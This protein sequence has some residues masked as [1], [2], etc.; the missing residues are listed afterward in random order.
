MS[1]TSDPYGLAASGL[2]PEL[3]AQYS[4]LTRQQAIAEAL[5]KQG[6]T[7]LQAPEVKGRFQGR[8][9]PW[10]GLAKLAQA[11]VG[12]KKLG[13]VQEGY[14]GL[15]NQRQQMVADALTKY[16]Q[17]KSGTPGQE[18]AQPAMSDEGDGNTMLPPAVKQGTHGDPR[19]ALVAAT[20]NPLLHGNPVVAA[21]LKKLEP[22]WQVQ[23]QFDS[24]GRKTKMLVNLNNPTETRPFGGVE[25][26]KLE[27]V[28]RANAK[29]G[30]P[31]DVFV[32]PQTQTEAIPAPVKL[33]AVNLGGKTEFRNP[34]QDQG[35]MAHTVSPDT[36]Y[37]RATQFVVAGVDENGKP[38][39]DTGNVVDAVG[40][41]D[42]KLPPP[43]SASKNPAAMARYNG[44]IGDIKSKYPEW[45]AQDYDSSRAALIA[46]SKGPEAKE[47]RNISTAIAHGGVFID[48]VKA[49]NNGDAPLFNKAANAIAV[50]TG[51]PAPTNLEAVKQIYG[52]EM[53]KAIVGGATAAEDRKKAAE[54]I[55]S[56]GSPAQ[57]LGVVQQNN[58]LLQGKLQGLRRQY[59]ASTKRKDFDKFLSQE[60]TQVESVGGAA[61][62]PVFDAADAILKGK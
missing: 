23:E 47:T 33:D 19:A 31:E 29:T 26:P 54:N 7:P 22:N 48:A 46:F 59:E 2:P 42:I 40:N 61:T 37:H 60:A 57:L 52:G 12:S 53:A 6:M 43:P 39:G 27:K 34:Y 10:E 14:A 44:L 50:A 36:I 8:I 11:Y 18:F 20:A 49:L 62:N 51:Q 32:N 9:S 16:E 4:G 28:T 1:A 41:H 58:N 35:P 38:I 17:A 25:Q 21:D 13:D 55:S 15:A 3:I 24:S 30:Q 45:N 5:M 56:A